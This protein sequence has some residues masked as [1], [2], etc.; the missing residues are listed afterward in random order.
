MFT[1]GRT[2]LPFP[3]LP[4]PSLLP[5]LV[6]IPCPALKLKTFPLRLLLV[7]VTA[8]PLLPFFCPWLS[9]TVLLSLSIRIPSWRFFSAL[10]LETMLLFGEPLSISRKMPRRLPLTW[11][12][13]TSVNVTSPSNTIPLPSSEE[14]PPPAQLFLATLL[15][16]KLLLLPLSSNSIPSLVLLVT[17]L[18]CT[19]TKVQP[20]SHWNPSSPLRSSRLFCTV[21]EE[22]WSKL[23]PSLLLSCMKLPVIVRSLE[24]LA[25]TPSLLNFALS[26][27]RVMSLLK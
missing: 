3:V 9:D 18:F 23:T 20:S 4:P 15:R 19:V 24:P 7:P 1:S 8:K 27:R 17:W 2:P 25:S 6:Q 22:T 13:D 16:I 21:L 26:L 11:F 14:H 5:A 12:P 10:L